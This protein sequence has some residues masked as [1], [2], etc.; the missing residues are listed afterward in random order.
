MKVMGQTYAW[1]TEY[2][3]G[4][5]HYEYTEPFQRSES[6]EIAPD[7]FDFETSI[8]EEAILTEDVSGNQIRFIVS[9]E[10]ITETAIAA[11]QQMNGVNNLKCEDVE[12]IATL[13][14]SG[15]INQ[16]V[17]NFDASVK[18]QGYDADVTYKI[19]YTFN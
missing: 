14:D 17:M 6:L 18:Y 2:Y 4:V 19:Q 11:V 12:V 16:I 8:P 9:G 15:S 3:D 13:N 10:E 1:S 7:F 5:A